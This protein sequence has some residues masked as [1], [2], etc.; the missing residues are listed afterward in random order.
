MAIL[1]PQEIREM[2]ISEM[3]EKLIEL[4]RELLKEY[5]HKATS[6]APSNPGRMREIRRT[7]ARI[8]TI[9]NEK[10]REQKQ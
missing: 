7:I 2:S 4:K 1:R 8:Y 5:T 6:G 10:R 9:M 3:K